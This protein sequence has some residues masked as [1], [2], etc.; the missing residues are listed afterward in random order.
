MMPVVTLRRVLARAMAAIACISCSSAGERAAD[1]GGDVD[2]ASEAGPDGAEVATFSCTQASVFVCTE[3]LAPASEMAAE[4][5]ACASEPG[6]FGGGCPRSGAFGCCAQ[7]GD[8]QCY[9]SGAEAT[10]AKSLCAGP[11][12]TWSMPDDQ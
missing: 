1:A 12:M 5:Q 6:T 2:G 9:Y 11:G 10:I 4:E 3:V 7:G 8:T